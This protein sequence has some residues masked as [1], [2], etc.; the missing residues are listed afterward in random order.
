MRCYIRSQQLAFLCL[1]DCHSISNSQLI[2]PLLPH[3]LGKFVLHF[4]HVQGVLLV[5]STTSRWLALVGHDQALRRSFFY[6]NKLHRIGP[7]C[8]I[9]DRRVVQI[10]KKNFE[11]WKDCSLAPWTIL[12]R[13]VAPK[14][15]LQ[16]PETILRFI[17]VSPSKSFPSTSIQQH[18]N[19]TRRDDPVLERDPHGR[20]GTCPKASAGACPIYH[21]TQYAPLAFFDASKEKRGMSNGHRNTGF[22]VPRRVRYGRL[23]LV[24][25]YELGPK[26]FRGIKNAYESGGPNGS[27]ISLTSAALLH[28][29]YGL[30][31]YA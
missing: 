18:K 9:Q 3:I 26:L 15:F 19:R 17:A 24:A 5:L 1:L 27:A 31:P 20:G 2:I 13:E 29:F 14:V 7:N 25:Q 6:K 30:E 22:L 23:H 28:P 11:S 10:E 12:V 21:A 16:P 4:G 8:R